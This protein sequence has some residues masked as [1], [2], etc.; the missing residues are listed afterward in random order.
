[1]NKILVIS[2][3]SSKFSRLN[4]ATKLLLLRHLISTYQDER[5]QLHAAEFLAQF[6][7]TLVV[8]IKLSEKQGNTRVISAQ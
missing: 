8:F 7:T 1:M 4:A 3:L 2:Y 6:H 5:A